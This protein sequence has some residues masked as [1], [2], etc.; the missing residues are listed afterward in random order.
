MYDMMSLDDFI[1]ECTNI[2]VSSNCEI[3]LTQKTCKPCFHDF[4]YIVEIFVCYIVF[5][6]D[7]S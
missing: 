7:T 2:G 1:H 3:S 4:V 6:C 5:L